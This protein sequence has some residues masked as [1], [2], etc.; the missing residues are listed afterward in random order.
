[1]IRGLWSAASGMHAQTTNIDV[2]ANNLANVNTTAFKTSKAQFQDLLYANIRSAGT[3]DGDGNMAPSGIQIGHGVKFSETSMDFTQGTI[4]D[5]DQSA[6]SGHVAI[7]G[8]GFFIVEVPG[9]IAYTR[10]GSFTIGADG[11]KTSQ[12]YKVTGGDGVD[13]SG[14]ISVDIRNDGSIHL[15]K[16]P[17]VG[18]S[19]EGQLELAV[20]TN[21]K[22]LRKIGGNLYVETFA[23][24]TPEIGT[25]GKL[26]FGSIEHRKLE[27]S[28]VKMVTEMVNMIAAQRAYEVGSKAI[29]TADSMLQATNQMKR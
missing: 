11:L 8:R 14:A 5:G 12:G 18:P 24:G 27:Q 4:I 19:P 7:S 22:G 2:I 6:L 28:N 29:S 21:P 20:F 10:D 16:P 26:N 17:V 3:E 23:S 13:T 9:G 1:M 25:P 15:D